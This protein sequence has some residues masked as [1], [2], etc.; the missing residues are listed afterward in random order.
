MTDS[1]LLGER[2]KL[3]NQYAEAHGAG[4][5]AQTKCAAAKQAIVAFDEEHQEV[6][7]MVKEYQ[8]NSKLQEVAENRAAAEESAGGEQ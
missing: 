4:M 7:L 5:A 8:K 6:M 2:Q 3:A 1:K